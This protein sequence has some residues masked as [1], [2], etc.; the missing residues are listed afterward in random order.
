MAPLFGRKQRKKTATTL[1]RIH[2][3]TLEALRAALRKRY[4]VPEG[5][6]LPLGLIRAEVD[7]ALAVHMGQFSHAGQLG[8][9][10]R[11]PSCEYEWHRRLSSKGKYGVC[12]RC[13]R[14]FSLPKP[15]P[16]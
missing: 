7:R 16:P 4:A 13:H 8:P 11:C 9:S 5:R 10:V 14:T 15:S 12:P 2:R 3:D 6:P 1:V